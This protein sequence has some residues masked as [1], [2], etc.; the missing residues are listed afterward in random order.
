MK[1]FL[2]DYNIFFNLEEYNITLFNIMSF[3]YLT[4]FDIV[5]VQYV[6]EKFTGNVHKAKFGSTLINKPFKSLKLTLRS[7]S[8]T[9]PPVLK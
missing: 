1:S 3:S 5:L 9:F 8:L 2:V 6:G 7:Q 4:S